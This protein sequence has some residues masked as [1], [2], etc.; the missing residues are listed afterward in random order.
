MNHLC[1]YVYLYLY[2]L[3]F[4]IFIGFFFKLIM[5]G[6]AS[7]FWQNSFFHLSV[8]NLYYFH[9]LIPYLYKIYTIF[10]QYDGISSILFISLILFL[11]Q[12]NL[13]LIFIIN[14]L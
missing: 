10:I 1:L 8:N 14:S 7:T 2:W 9:S 12:I 5:F 3:Y 13:Y 11:I 6:L 4:S